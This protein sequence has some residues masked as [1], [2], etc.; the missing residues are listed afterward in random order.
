MF[1][2]HEPSAPSYVGLSRADA[3]ARG[4]AA[5]LVVRVM[6]VDGVVQGGTA[7]YRKDRVNLGIDHGKVTSA[8]RY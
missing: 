7:D 3:L 5:G 8:R 6:C 2:A 1:G 4:A